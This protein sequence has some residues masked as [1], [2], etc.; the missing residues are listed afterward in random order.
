MKRRGTVSPAHKKRLDAAARVQIEVRIAVKQVLRELEEK[1]EATLS[2][3]DV[4]DILG[5]KPQRKGRK[6]CV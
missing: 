6:S 3:L 5:L 2:N 4:A 1:M